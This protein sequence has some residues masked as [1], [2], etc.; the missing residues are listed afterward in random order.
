MSSIMTITLINLIQQTIHNN[1]ASMALSDYHGEDYTYGDIALIIDHY[2]SLFRQLAIQQGDRI[3]I[4]GNGSAQWGISFFATITYGAV[5]VPILP[6][7]TP[8]QIQNIVKHSEARLLF[9]SA[10]ISNTLDSSE[11]SQ[12]SKILLI[13]DIKKVSP[14]QQTP[15]IDWPAESSPNDVMML[16]YTSGTTGSSKGVMLPYRAFLGNYDFFKASWHW[17]TLTMLKLTNW[18]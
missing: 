11:L 6:G 2:H 15:A 12:L 3:A 1:W 18:D 5:A 16:N 17:Y 4:C 7:F 14:S 10:Q 13:E 9:A 8:T